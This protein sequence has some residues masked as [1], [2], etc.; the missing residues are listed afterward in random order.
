MMKTTIY[1]ILLLLLVSLSSAELYNT[2]PLDNSNNL[3]EWTS[4]LNTLSGGVV[5]IGIILIVGIIAFS[6]NLSNENNPYAGIA[7]ACFLTGLISIILLPLGLL[8]T[9]AFQIVILIDSL[10]LILVLLFGKGG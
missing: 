8:D 6:T 4:G 7:A 5:G 3:Y 2:T 9:N 1:V 10:G